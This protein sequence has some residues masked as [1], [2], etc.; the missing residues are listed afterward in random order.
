MPASQYPFA[1]FVKNSKVWLYCAKLLGS[2]NSPKAGDA[3]TALVGLGL[4]LALV[5][6]TLRTAAPSR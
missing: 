2:N 4:A 1:N 5:R 6:A 3:Q